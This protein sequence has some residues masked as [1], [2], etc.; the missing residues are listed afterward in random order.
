M[1]D[2]LLRLPK[3]TA[4]W[5]ESKSNQLDSTRRAN[6]GCASGISVFSSYVRCNLLVVRVRC[7]LMAEPM[8]THYR[9]RGGHARHAPRK[10]HPLWTWVNTIFAIVV[11]VLALFVAGWFP[12]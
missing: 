7:N 6:H 5:N 4:D 9:Y 2:E 8:K 12:R 1:W 11:F 10:R 3:S